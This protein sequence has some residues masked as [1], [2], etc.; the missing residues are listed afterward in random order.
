V[1]AFLTTRLI[2]GALPAWNDASHRD[3]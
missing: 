3:G 2:V 1:I